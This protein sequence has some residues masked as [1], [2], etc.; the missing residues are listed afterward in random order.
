M[1]TCG[2]AFFSGS[3]ASSGLLLDSI[4]PVAVAVSTRKLRSAYSGSAIR[5]RR[6]Q[7]NVEADIGFDSNGDLDVNALMSHVGAENLL[8]NSGAPVTQSVTLIA[9]TYTLKLIGSGSVTTSAG[10]ASG[11]GFGTATQGS[12]NVFTVTIGG[13]VTFTCSGSITR[14]QLNSG[15]T[16]VD[17][18]PTTTSATTHGQNLLTYSQDFSN[19]AWQKLSGTTVTAP[20]GLIGPN[21]VQAYRVTFASGSQLPQW[22]VPLASNPGTVR[23]Y[24]KRAPSGS[25]TAIRLTTNNTSAW[26]T[27][28]SGKLVLTDNWQPLVVSGTLTNTSQLHFVIGAIDVTG[29]ADSDCVGSVD[30]AMASLNQGLTIHPY[31]ATTSAAVEK[32][33]GSVT[34]MYDQ[35]GNSRDM[36][37]AATASPPRITIAGLIDRMGTSTNRPAPRAFG[38]SNLRS[39]DFLVIQPATRCSS[40]QFLAPND[41]SV[42]F[43]GYLDSTVGGVSDVALFSNSSGAI[44]TKLGSGT[45]ISIATGQTPGSSA[46]ISEVFNGASSLA[47]F[48][49]SLTS[50]SSFGTTSIAGLVIGGDYAN[51]S[52]SKAMFGDVIILGSA[53]STANRTALEANMRAYWGTP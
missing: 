11:T 43:P 44:Y 34:K 10:S 37:P 20:A 21:G 31:Q 26:S 48:N 49:G 35:S 29:N 27:G 47:S 40:I 1:F 25:A 33:A 41:S 52:F 17:Y 14:F 13:S 9:G 7:D 4:G 28:V 5:V 32:G 19:T 51:S 30:I 6:S 46:T 2:P 18:C 23:I 53:L 16:A 50:I 42:T 22:N 45:D 8:L 38:A 12:N 15:S 39:I 24:A 36:A 3:A